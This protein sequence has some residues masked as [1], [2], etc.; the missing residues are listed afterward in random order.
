M[1]SEQS[2]GNELGSE[3][4][5]GRRL[6]KLYGER[7]GLFRVLVRSEPGRGAKKSPIFFPLSVSLRTPKRVFGEDGEVLGRM[8]GF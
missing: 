4:S 8:V 1:G 2:L 3:Q 5:L 7:S 6:F